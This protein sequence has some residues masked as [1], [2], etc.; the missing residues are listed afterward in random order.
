MNNGYFGKKLS[1]LVFDWWN[2]VKGNKE[3][4]C[5]ID[6]NELSKGAGLL[7]EHFDESK[8]IKDGKLDFAEYANGHIHEAQNLPKPSK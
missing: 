5:K 7:F 3:D 2:T 4:R 1:K 6:S 8:P